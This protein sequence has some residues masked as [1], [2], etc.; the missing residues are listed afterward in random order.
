MAEVVASMKR[1]G[2]DMSFIIYILLALFLMMVLGG[3]SFTVIN[4]AENS[5]QGC[6]IWASILSDISEGVLQM[7]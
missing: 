6:G 7:C 5:V 1:K 3:A 4:S 2:F